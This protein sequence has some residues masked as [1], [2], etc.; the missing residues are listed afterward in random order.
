M[1]NLYSENLKEFPRFEDAADV[2]VKYRDLIA[3]CR[4]LVPEGMEGEYLTDLVCYRFLKGWKFDATKASTELNAMLQ[5]R[6]DNTMD[7]LRARIGAMTPAQREEEWPHLA[8]LRTC[9]PCS[10]H[11]E[12]DSGQPI[13]LERAGKIDLD[14]LMRGFTFEQLQQYFRFDFEYREWLLTKLTAERGQL[15]RQ[16]RVVDLSGLG[17]HHVNVSALTMLKKLLAEGTANYPESLG[18]MFIVNTPWA[19]NLMWSGVKPLLK[20]STQK[21]INILGTE[22]KEALLKAIKAE[23]LPK[24]L[25]GD[26]ACAAKGE[27][28]QKDED[29]FCCPLG[30]PHEGMSPATV[31]AGKTFEHKVEVGEGD[32]VTWRFFTKSYS[33]KF[34]VGF[35]FA[36]N[37]GGNALD[38]LPQKVLESHTSIADGSISS[39]GQ[40]TL[41]LV[42]DN[43][44]S[45]VYAKALHF[46]VSSTVAAD[47]VTEEKAEVTGS[48]EENTE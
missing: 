11:G 3:E 38:L 20:E 18:T 23:N 21:K 9:F 48:A 43:T 10:F 27:S 17:K 29:G 7:D 37:A 30:D 12:D 5:W 28:D 34:K 1:S 2:T 46:K 32:V 36:Q 22:Y 6:K 13:S 14:A 4:S 19:F 25:G 24:F 41:V 44:D 47:L 16:C 31:P 15:V 33:V 26:C 42:W 45:W 39:P 35:V 40:G 8:K